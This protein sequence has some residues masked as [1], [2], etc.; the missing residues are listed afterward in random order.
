MM[1]FHQPVKGKHAHSHILIP[2]ALCKKK[3]KKIAKALS[4]VTESV[5]LLVTFVSLEKSAQ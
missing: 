5:I 4:K 2:L 3:L 1:T